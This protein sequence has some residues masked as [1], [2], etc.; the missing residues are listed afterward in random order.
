MGSAAAVFASKAKAQDIPPLSEQARFIMS[1]YAQAGV[2]NYFFLDKHAA[3]FYIIESGKIILSSDAIFGRGRGEDIKTDSN[4]TPA[5]VFNFDEKSLRNS[6]Y[7]GSFLIFTRRPHSNPRYEDYIY[8]IHSTYKGNPKEHR[9]QRYATPT[10]LDNAISAGCINLPEHAYKE[11]LNFYHRTGYSII[12]NGR[13]KMH[14][15][16]FF[17]LPKSGDINEAKK[18]LGIR[19]I[20]QITY[21][22]N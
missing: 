6:T 17:S 19:D 16:S 13:E 4:V 2:E 18:F 11:L 20:S 22:N 3:K 1:H 15:P 7:F 21:E 8:A 5:G 9:E 10:P 12:E 14:Y